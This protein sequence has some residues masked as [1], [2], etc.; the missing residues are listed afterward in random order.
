MPKQLPNLNQLN[1]HKL[2]LIHE[3]VKRLIFVTKQCIQEQDAKIRGL[4]EKLLKLQA[5]HDANFMLIKQ[6]AEKVGYV[7]TK[8][9]S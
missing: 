4:E 2:G 1:F 8:T 3:D 7:I 5:E 6:L 9:S